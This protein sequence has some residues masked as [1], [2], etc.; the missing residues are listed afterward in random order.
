MRHSQSAAV[1]IHGFED[2]APEDRARV[3]DSLADFASR[4]GLSSGVSLPSLAAGTT[5]RVETQNSHYRIVV[6]DGPRGRVLIH[7]GRVFPED[8]V[9][10][11]EGATRGGSALRVGW[12]G[13]GLRLELSTGYGRVV[14]S[15]VESIT[16]EDD[17]PS[18]LTS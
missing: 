16:V 1:P 14:T 17:R 8:T 12:I 7:G 15:P 9:A 4:A 2:D 18:A 11:V 5:V 10:N 6:Q 13:E 3:E